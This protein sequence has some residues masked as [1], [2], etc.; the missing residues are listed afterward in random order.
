MMIFNHFVLLGND[1]CMIELIKT[2]LKNDS[3]GLSILTNNS[4]CIWL[5]SFE[6]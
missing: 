2:Y 6:P 1:T 5:V 4:S 3:H